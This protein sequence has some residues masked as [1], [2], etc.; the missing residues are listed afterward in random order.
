MFKNFIYRNLILLF[1]LL[2]LDGCSALFQTGKERD[3]TSV[4]L[5]EVEALHE[6]TL[7]FERMKRVDAALFLNKEEFSSLFNATFDD[8]AKHFSDL[9]APGFSHIS[10]SIPELTLDNQRISSQVAFSFEVDALKRKIFGHLN[11]EHRLKAGTNVFV[12]D[13]D[14]NEIVLDRIEQM[15][16]FEENS[17]NKDIIGGSVKSF[18]HTL[19]IEIINMPLVIPVDMNIMSGVNGKDIYTSA[20]YKLHSARAVNIQTKMEM[21]LPYIC[22]RG[23][24]MLG[25]SE[26]HPVHEIVR[27]DDVIASRNRLS[28]KIDSAL[29]ENMGISLET[30]QRHSSY[31][32]SKKYL[33]KQMNLALRNMDLRVINKFFL[34]LPENESRFSKEIF[35]F[36]KARLPSCEGVKKDCSG[37][38]KNCD[39][40]CGLKFG[41]HRCDQCADMTNPFEQVRCMSKLEACKS[42]EELRVY[43]CN[44]RENR[45]YMQNNEIQS[46]CEI[47]NLEVVSVCQEKKE[48]LNFVDDELLLVRLN[49]DFDIA[50]SYAVQKIGQI[51]FDKELDSLEVIRDIHVSVDSKLNF[52]LEKSS[53][54]DFNCSLQMDEALLTHSQADHVQEKRKMA[55]STQR[56]SDG[57]MLIK[58]VSKPTF[59]TTRLDKNPYDKLMKTKNFSL[60]CR[61]QDIPMAPLKA[62]ELLTKQDI[63]YT[64]NA[65]LTEIDLPFEEE[66]FSFVISG[67]SLGRDILLYPTMEKQSIGFSRQA[68][69]Y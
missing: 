33:S 66:E 57:K 34:K 43:E 3:Q 18:M 1:L 9:D 36:D 62:E 28:H 69:F 47:K 50:N 42:K 53:L 59:M 24:T 14:F 44:K 8:F 32:M 23:V 55:L 67:V 68:H 63:P 52:G 19:N 11:A 56:T 64:L 58:A 4:E 51:I 65:M 15:E 31:Y 40:K 2:F 22:E 54:A 21:Y 49:V 48:A 16:A 20:D 39:G 5:Q 17:E 45:C 27:L 12:L 30:L 38:L 61:Y 37:F 10:F 60:V 26:L 46:A 13:T 29:M 7:L 6:T 41:A 35:F 25:S